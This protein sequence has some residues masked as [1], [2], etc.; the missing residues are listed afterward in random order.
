MIRKFLFA[1]CA[2]TLSLSPVASQDYRLR[3]GDLIEV[4]VLED[5]N[6][7]RRLLVRPDGKVSMPVAGT[8][9]AAG[10]TPE[11]LQ[12]VLRDRLLS[13]F[14]DPPTVTVTLIG[15]GPEPLPEPF[16]EPEEEEVIL[17]AV[18]VIGEVGNPG[19]VEMV[20]EMTILQVLA[21][22]GGPG[23]FAARS[24]IQVRRLV[25]GSEEIF[26]LDYDAIEEG[27]TLPSFVVLNGDIIV[28][29]ERGLFD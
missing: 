4:S 15:L 16:P 14:V 28:V 2:F 20:T 6:F 24:R 19:K 17:P 12:V 21:M 22:A 3:L 25:D 11:Q 1:I 26:L 9:R 10:V 29:P 7:N 5:P 8:V 23:P 13:A 27:S 18:Y